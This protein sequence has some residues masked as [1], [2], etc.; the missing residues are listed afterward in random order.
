MSSQYFYF[1]GRSFKH[2]N[3]HVINFKINKRKEERITHTHAHTHS[4]NQCS[5]VKS[6]KFFLESLYLCVFQLG[7]RQ[8]K[9]VAI[10]HFWLITFYHVEMCVFTALDWPIDTFGSCSQN[11]KSVVTVV[12]G[13]TDIRIYA[14]HGV[15]T[16]GE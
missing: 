6:S 10:K 4:M 7:I 3:K 12:A 13:N 14:R 11:E 8:N 1:Q 16:L 2:I 5:K 9:L 15:L